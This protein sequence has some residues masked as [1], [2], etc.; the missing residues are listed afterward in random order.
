MLDILKQVLPVYL[1]L[2]AG[3]ALRRMGVTRRENDDGILHLV[4]HV[5]YPCFILDR[6]LGSESVRDFSTVAW[7]IGLGFLFPIVGM[8]MAWWVAG[9]LGYAKGTGRRTF[10]LTSGVQNFGYT[11]IP[12]VAQL[13]GVGGGAMALLFV[14]NLGVELALWS[15]GVMLISGDKRVPWRRLVNGPVVAV[16]ISLSL[17]A[18]GWDRAVIGPPRKAIEWLGAGAF[19]VAIFVTGAVIMDLLGKERPT[20]KASLGGSMLRLAL[21][22]AVML[23]VTKF[24]PAPVELK[25][26]LVVQAAMP[27]ALTPIL[28]AKLYGGRPAVAV[29]IVVASTLLSLITLPLILAWGRAFVGI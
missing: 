9:L 25:Q 2:I 10:A 8:L 24:V 12:V 28:L 5:M 1:L 11:A 29:E 22:P 27:A 18:L 23:L 16:V 20:W 26:V 4:F 19:P 7:G 14:H 13:W 17:V 6:V 3:A 21:I 15:I